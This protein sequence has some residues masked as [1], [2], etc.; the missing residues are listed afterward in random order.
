MDFLNKLMGAL[1]P[2]QAPE[3]APEAQTLVVPAKPFVNHHALQASSKR[4]GMWVMDSAGVGILTGAR[5]DGDA[6][7]T[8]I[9]PDGST[10]MRVGPDDTAI[11]HVAVSPFAA[12]RQARIHEI[13]EARRGD[14]A[15]LAALGYQN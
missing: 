7:V 2:T 13:P 3:P 9:K 11:P 15:K 14:P 12:L 6:E 10:L 4:L 8:L 5:A 1:R